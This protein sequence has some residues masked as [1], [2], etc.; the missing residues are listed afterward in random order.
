[1]KTSLFCGTSRT[2]MVAA[3]GTTLLTALPALAEDTTAALNAAE[4]KS[5]DSGKSA[6]MAPMQDKGVEERIKHLHDQL[7]VTPDQEAAWGKVAQV[8]RDNAASMK[9][10]FE[11]RKANT[12]LTAPEDIKS[13][14][15]MT[16]AHADALDK[17]ADSFGTFYDTLTPEQQKNADRVFGHMEQKQEHEHKNKKQ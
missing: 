11:A 6:D 2:L 9:S 1:M 3:L 7:K 13:L 14:Q 4:L 8:M 12:N 5:I 17:F 10:A 15:K 16:Q